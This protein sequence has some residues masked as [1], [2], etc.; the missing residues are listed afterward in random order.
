M[1]T[2]D[3]PGAHA[4]N[5]DTLS[6]GC[7]AE[8]DDGSLILVEGVEPISPG[9]PKNR[10]VY[11]IFDT[12]KTPV[13]EFRDAMDEDRFKSQFSWR[14]GLSK[15]KWVWHD[16][17]PFPWSRAIKSGISDGPRFSNLVDQL[18]S[19][20]AAADTAAV[21]VALALGIAN[22]GKPV[23][24]DEL[25]RLMQDRRVRRIAERLQRAIDTLRPGS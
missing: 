20:Q 19:A 15:D 5:N 8:H 18:S 11:S 10:V 14:T 23:D 1:S 24:P 9:D 17:T 21:R 16:K 7:W 13:V 3:V 4:A 2:N 12:A 6:M 25:S 22:T